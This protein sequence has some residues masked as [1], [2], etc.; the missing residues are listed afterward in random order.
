MLESVYITLNQV[1][2]DKTDI[3]PQADENDQ[4]RI[5]VDMIIADKN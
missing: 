1:S 2:L 5:I 3:I 4:L